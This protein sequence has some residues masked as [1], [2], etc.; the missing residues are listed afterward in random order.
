MCCTNVQ[1]NPKKQEENRLMSQQ[2]SHTQHLPSGPGAADRL[3][4]FT[5]NTR[6]PQ[7][8]QPPQDIT[9]MAH[10]RVSIP[11]CVCPLS[12]WHNEM[13]KAMTTRVGDSKYVT[14]RD[15]SK[16]IFPLI[17]PTSHYI[18]KGARSSGR[19]RGSCTGGGH[20]RSSRL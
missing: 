18:N 6:P 5:G 20:R 12:V 3:L 15:C 1:K 13:A 9:C 8:P 10:N 19:V 11:I 14:Q 16:T 2:P 7:L 4:T 17:Q